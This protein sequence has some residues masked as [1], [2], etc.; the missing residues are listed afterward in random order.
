ME[1]VMDEGR[2]CVVS[3]SEVQLC[4]AWTLV[5]LLTQNLERNLQVSS[6]AQVWSAAS[7]PRPSFTLSILP[8]FLLLTRCCF[9]SKLD[10]QM[11]S[12]IFCDRNADVA[13][14]R[15]LSLHT[16]VCVW[17]CWV[18]SMTDA[19]RASR[20]VKRINSSCERSTIIAK[21]NLRRHEGLMNAHRAV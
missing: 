18:S 9:E 16:S 21:K 20:S 6:G 14:G 5:Y 19:V 8:L 7:L 1:A 17:Q 2:S 4:S 11:V 3:E 13:A 15:S 12:L 10:F